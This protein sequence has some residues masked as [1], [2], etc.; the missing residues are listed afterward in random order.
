MIKKRLSEYRIRELRSYQFALAFGAL[1]V[2]LG[3]IIGLFQYFSTVDMSKSS[4]P[5]IIKTS[6]PEQ[7]TKEATISSPIPSSK[8]LNVAYA[9]QAP[10]GNWTIHEESCEEAALYMYQQYFSGKKYSS[11]RIP[12][13]EADIVY[14]DMKG[15]QTSHYGKEP[16]LTMSALGKFAKEYYGLSYETKDATEINIKRAISDGKPVIVPVMTHS[17]ENNMYGPYSVYHVLFIKGFDTNGVLTNDAGVGNGQD[18]HYSWNTLWKAIDAQKVQ[19][20]QGRV[21]LT[22]SK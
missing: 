21:M 14:R 17:L 19:M 2:F 12:D 10:F 3:T 1:V 18:H 4:E 9:A 11:N 6:E 16:D 8:T 22:L 7:R 5:N 20:N 15:W 13:A